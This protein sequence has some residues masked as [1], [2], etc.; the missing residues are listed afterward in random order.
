MEVQLFKTDSRD[1]LLSLYM[2]FLKEQGFNVTYENR[3]GK[4]R[5]GYINFEEM[6]GAMFLAFVFF[7]AI[8]IKF[9]QNSAEL[10][11]ELKKTADNPKSVVKGLI[12]NNKD[13]LLKAQ[14][15]IEYFEV[16]QVYK[17]KDNFEGTIDP[18]FKNKTKNG[19]IK[20]IIGVGANAMKIIEEHAMDI[21]F[22]D[23]YSSNTETVERENPRQPSPKTGKYLEEYIKNYEKAVR[24]TNEKGSSPKRNEFG[25]FSKVAYTVSDEMPVASTVSDEMHVAS[26]VSAEMPVASTVSN[27]KPVASDANIGKENTSSRK[28]RMSPLAQ[29]YLDAANKIGGSKTR[30]QKRKIVES[31]RKR[32]GSKK[33]KRR[34]HK[35]K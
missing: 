35:R 1:A 29:R 5:G 10:H 31:K 23:V 12:E 19:I 4:M 28:K 15:I 13:D 22:G 33:Q 21:N 25:I 24:K 20:S 8:N 26:T 14:E 30:G 6:V 17:I 32:G 3:G 11:E 27:E 18:I 34:S 7:I 2:L 16:D 9:P